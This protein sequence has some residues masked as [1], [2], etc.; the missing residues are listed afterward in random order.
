[1]QAGSIFVYGR[2]AQPVA[3]GRQPYVARGNIYN[4]KMYSKHL[5][6]KAETEGRCNFDNL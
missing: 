2:P 4:E 3:G 5:F 1:M 6:G